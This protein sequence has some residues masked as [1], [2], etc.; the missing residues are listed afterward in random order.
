MALHVVR[1]LRR[2]QTLVHNIFNGET[3]QS[4]RVDAPVH[5]WMLGRVRAYCGG[6]RE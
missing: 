5:A 2:R 6:A 4:L 1:D 3:R